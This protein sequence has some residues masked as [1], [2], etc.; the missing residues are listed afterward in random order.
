MTKR[1]REGFVRVEGGRVWY[2][3][4]G[5]SG[6][7]LPLITLHGGPG[8]PHD[9]LEPLEALADER[10]VIFYDQLGCGKSDR[11]TDNKLWRVERFVK[12]LAQL[13]SALK[14]DRAHILGQSWGTMLAVDYLLT[15]PTGVASVILADPAISIPRWIADANRL[16][17]KLPKSVRAT[18]DRHEKAGNIEC[19]EY[20]AATL[21]FYKRHVCRLEPWPP[22]M[23]R[24]MRGIG[25]DVYGTMWGPNEFIASGTLRNYDRSA[26]LREI[27]LPTLL[28]CGRYDEATPESTAFYRRQIR[29]A[30]M[31]VFEKSS[32]MPQLEEPVKYNRVVRD[33]LRRAERQIPTP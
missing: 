28:L 13:R 19:L 30:E 32:H 14:L 22:A 25:G 18:L 12:E 31:A 16:R 4:V 29:G 9:Y 17:R 26:R 10:A 33:F 20:Q 5:G 8:A 1:A 27:S 2:R 3:I 6:G 15:R 23:E 24:M 7:G 11:P 21:A